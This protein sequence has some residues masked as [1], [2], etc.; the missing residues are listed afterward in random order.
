MRRPDRAYAQAWASKRGS[1]IVAHG[2]RKNAVNALLEA[3]CSVG[4]VSS[5]SGQS[6]A[7]VEHYA[8]RRSNRKLAVSAIGRLQGAKHEQENH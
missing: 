6:L 5:V 1:K 3:G 2:L 7:L 4:E 8:K